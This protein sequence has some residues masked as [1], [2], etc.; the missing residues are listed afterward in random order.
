[1]NKLTSIFTDFQSVLSW[2]IFQIILIIM[3][4]FLS[5]RYRISGKALGILGLF[6]LLLSFLAS[7]FQNDILAGAFSEIV[8]ILFVFAFIVE[9]IHFLKNENK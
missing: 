1:M 6:F 4:I 5:L 7:L 3:L 8:W 9:F 2:N